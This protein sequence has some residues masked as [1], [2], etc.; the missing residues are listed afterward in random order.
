MRRAAADG[1]TQ[2]GPSRDLGLARKAHET[3]DVELMVAA[4]DAQM[5]ADRAAE[6]HSGE[7]SEYIKSVVFGGL[8]GIVTTF[9]IVCAAVGAGLGPRIVRAPLAAVPHA[10][11]PA[12]SPNNHPPPPIARR[13]SSWA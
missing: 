6:V 12:R 1:P 13:S 4:H 7:A 9:A 8:D 5:A 10:P 2:S 11:P 3:E